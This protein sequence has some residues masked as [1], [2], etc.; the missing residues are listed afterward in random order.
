MYRG[1]Q[2][3]KISVPA[4]PSIITRLL[5]LTSLNSAHV[6]SILSASAE[7]DW[8]SNVELIGYADDILVIAPIATALDRAQLQTDLHKIN[9]HYHSIGLELNVHKSK[10]LFVAISRSVNFEGV[11][12]SLQG[13][14][15]PVV[16]DLRYLGV[17]LNQNLSFDGH[18]EEV[19]NKGKRILGALFAACKGLSK[20]QLRHIYK[21]KILP[22]FYILFLSLVL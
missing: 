14:P 6:G 10:A 20:E 13:Q 2:H 5:Q 21:V 17:T 9:A 11:Y 4:L 19:V 3:V 16:A 22:I 8:S 1:L 7:Q 15:L 12:F 18:A